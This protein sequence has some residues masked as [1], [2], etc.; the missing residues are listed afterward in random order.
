FVEGDMTFVILYVDCIG[1]LQGDMDI[2]RNDPKLAGLKIDHILIGATHAHDGPDTV[3]LWGPS[4][5][6]TGRQAFVMDRLH[7]ASVDAIVDAVT[8]AQPAQM[9]IASTKLI[10]DP[11]NNMS[12]TDDFNKDIRDPIIFDPTLTIARFVKVGAPNET[13]G[14]L[15]NWADH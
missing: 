8:S 7:A 4:P 10:N 3:G 5:T 14:T 13:I 11:A 9:V 2:I 15:V 6:V 12:K 1:L